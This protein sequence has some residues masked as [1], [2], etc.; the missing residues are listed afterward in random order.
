MIANGFRNVAIFYNLMIT[1]PFYIGPSLVSNQT[2]ITGI[3]LLLE[4]ISTT[5]LRESLL[6]SRHSI[7]E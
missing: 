5:S 7:L 2:L 3:A 4:D 1:Q 6:T